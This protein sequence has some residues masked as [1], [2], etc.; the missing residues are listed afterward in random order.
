MDGTGAVLVVREAGGGRLPAPQCP[1]SAG[2]RGR[3]G[4]QGDAQGVR[5]AAAPAGE[6]GRAGHPGGDGASPGPPV[7]LPGLRWSEP[8]TVEGSAPIGECITRCVGCRRLFVAGE[9]YVARVVGPVTLG[10]PAH[11]ACT[12]R[13]ELAV[14]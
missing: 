6:S 2:R 3:F 9:Q 10:F 1:R 8:R 12:E 13:A 11:V 5:P 14:A 7:T 4:R